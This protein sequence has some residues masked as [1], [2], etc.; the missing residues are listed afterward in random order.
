MIVIA[1]NLTGRLS[2]T[3]NYLHMHITLVQRVSK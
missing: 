2:P 1:W 3:S